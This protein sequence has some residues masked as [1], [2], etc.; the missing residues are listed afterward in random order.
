MIDHCELS[1]DPSYF[2]D[3]ATGSQYLLWKGDTWNPVR[4]SAIYLQ[5]LSEDGLSLAPGSQPSIIL[6]D[7]GRSI[8]F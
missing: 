8:S 3:P 6:T 1:P 2:W 5:Q 7:R 4:I